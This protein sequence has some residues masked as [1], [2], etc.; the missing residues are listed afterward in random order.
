MGCRTALRGGG[1][2]LPNMIDDDG[3]GAARGRMATNG[4]DGKAAP[5][6]RVEADH[7]RLR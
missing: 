4:C 6:S 5:S 1:A 3:Y 7:H 2:G